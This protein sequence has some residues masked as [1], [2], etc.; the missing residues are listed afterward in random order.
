MREVEISSDGYSGKA[1]FPDEYIFAFNPNYADVTVTD[2]TNPVTVKVAS[3][4]ASYEVEA[5]PYNNNVKVYI[6]RLVQLLFTDSFNVRSI[7][8]TISAIV[9]GTT[10]A[11]V[12]AVA[13]WS[14]L[15]IGDQLGKYGFYVF[16][17]LQ[18]LNHIR[19]VTWF[20]NFPFKVSMFKGTDSNDVIINDGGTKTTK[21]VENGG[22]FDLT[23]SDDFQGTESEMRYSVN[24]T[25]E[26]MTTFETVFDYTF[27]NSYNNINEIV[28]L[29]V[30]TSTAGYYIRWIDRF[31]FLQYYL[32]TK[33]E[34]TNK[35]KQDDIEIDDEKNYNGMYFGNLTRLRQI[36]NSTS[37]KCSAVLLDK[38]TLPYVET[39]ICSPYVDL[40]L[41]KDKDGTE[42]WL[43]IKVSAGSYKVA[44][45]GELKDYE[46][47][48][49]LPDTITQTL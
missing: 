30:D 19:K 29:K 25:S 24:I 32:F 33:G 35:T 22:I 44:A 8:I 13:L 16:D 5:T 31:G 38:N 21:T 10:L 46:I 47:T 7:D 17:G 18:S 43:P 34:R 1:V 11:S 37:I 48:I 12:T 27:T 45:K 41:G 26:T 14:G 42:I 49:E 3:T 15:Q 40:Y 4:A 6:S 9:G 36:T 20:K 28:Q 23:P 2:L 39:V